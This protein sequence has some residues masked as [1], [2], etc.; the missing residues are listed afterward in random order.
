MGCEKS[1]QQDLRD[2]SADDQA[3]M[4]ES[5]LFGHLDLSNSGNESADIYKPRN[6]STDVRETMMEKRETDPN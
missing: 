6:E 3:T 1:Q 2:A 4:R 5:E